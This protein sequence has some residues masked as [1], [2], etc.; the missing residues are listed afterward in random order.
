M[1]VS[2]CFFFLESLN[3][4]KII[5][6]SL[7]IDLRESGIIT[8]VRDQGQCGG[9]WAFAVVCACEAL[10][11]RQKNVQ[12]PDFSEQQ[13]VDC[14]KALLLGIIRRN[15]GCNGGQLLASKSFYILFLSYYPSLF[16]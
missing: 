1:L 4:S 8:D 5:N 9:C 14:S 15:N 13:L 6:L 2:H 10:Y 7:N 12:S 11:T 16:S 3:I